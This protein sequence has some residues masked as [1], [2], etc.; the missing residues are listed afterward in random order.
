MAPS[1]SDTS[2]TATS[3]AAAVAVQGI[4]SR[5]LTV[6]IGSTTLAVGA[7]LLA[8]L[9]AAI[10]LVTLVNLALEFSFAWRWGRRTAPAGR[11]F[12]AAS[13]KLPVSY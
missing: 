7:M 4:R 13:S 11:I 2:V 8:P 5:L 10:P 6:W 12:S 9:V 3:D 1:D